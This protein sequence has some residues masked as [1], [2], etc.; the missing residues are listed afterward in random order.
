MT[1]HRATMTT[2]PAIALIEFAGIAAGTRAA[3]A[4]VKRAPITT[5]RFGTVQPGKFLVL[6]GGSVAAVEESRREGLAIGGESIT[7]EIFLPDVHEQVF[8]A[9]EGGRK[10]NTG[11]ALGIIESPLI[12]ATVAAADKAVK[13]AEVTIIEVRLGDGLG[14]KGVTHMCGAV[15]DV[16]AAI[17][18]GVAVFARRGSTPRYTVIPIQHQETR[19]TIASGT[20]FFGFRAGGDVT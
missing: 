4:M 6:V 18:A 9:L 7:D 11:D 5:Y 1:H 16:Q 20:S 12:P 8:S 10:A 2:P 17:E 15:H 13:T 14:G 19:A 3:D